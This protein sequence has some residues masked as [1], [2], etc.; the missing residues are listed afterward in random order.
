MEIDNN[1]KKLGADYEA[2]GNQEIDSEIRLNEMQ[3]ERHKFDI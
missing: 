3:Q 1:L 2:A